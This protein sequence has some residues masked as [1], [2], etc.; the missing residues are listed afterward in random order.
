MSKMIPE[1]GPIDWMSNRDGVFFLDAPMP[2][3]RHRCKVQT[4]ARLSTCTVHRCACGALRVG[5][6]GFWNSKN[7]RIP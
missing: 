4:T 5:V 3:K 1:K 6:I 2:P 7:S